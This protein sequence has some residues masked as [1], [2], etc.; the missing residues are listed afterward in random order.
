MTKILYFARM[1]QVAGR[2]EENVDIP[3]EVKTIRALMAHLA[4]RDEA[5]AHAFADERIVRAA[6]NRTHVQ[7]DAVIAGAEEIAFFPPVTGG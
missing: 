4:S 1:R 3:P 5:L 7:L 6:I 2:A